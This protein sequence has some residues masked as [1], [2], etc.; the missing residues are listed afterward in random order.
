MEEKKNDRGIQNAQALSRMETIRK[1]VILALESQPSSTSAKVPTFFRF[2]FHLGHCSAHFASR[3]LE[4]LCSLFQ[5]RSPVQTHF[6]VREARTLRFVRWKQWQALI[7]SPKRASLAQLA[8]ARGISPKRDPALLMLLFL[9]PCLGGGG[10]ARLSET[11]SPE[12][13]PSA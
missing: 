3:V 5:C 11:V 8:P 2:T 1:I 10:G 7:N 6:Q 13:D 9:C 12:R 4:L